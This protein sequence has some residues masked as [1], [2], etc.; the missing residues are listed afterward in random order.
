MEWR[1]LRALV[2][3]IK[4]NSFSRAAQQLN[5]TQSTVSKTVSQ[6]EEELGIALIDRT[7]HACRPTGGGE[8]VNRH[9]LELLRGYTRL[10][11]E[12]DELRWLNRGTLRLGLQL[13]G[14][15]AAI[16]EV[17]AEFR[18][19]YPQ[20]DLQLVED[21]GTVVTQML[22]EGDLDLATVLIPYGDEFESDTRDHKAV[23]FCVLLPPGHTLGGHKPVSLSALA[24]ESFVLYAEGARMGLLLID[25][26]KGVGFTPTIAAR[27]AHVEFIAELVSLGLGVA[28]VPQEILSRLRCDDVAVA[29]LLVD[30]PLCSVTIAWR[31]GSKLSHAANAW[32]ALLRGRT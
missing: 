4:Q 32:L 8:I 15:D 20:I 11:T 22:R 23:E 5:L 29:P 14:Q 2:E 28:V 18:R 12:L 1:Q 7:D 10:V 13:L 31:K 17:F 30:H 25:A 26:C 6:L 27:S 16:A 19:A 21:S 9:A 3:V 24:K